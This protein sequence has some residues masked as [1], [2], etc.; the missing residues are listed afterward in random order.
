MWTRSQE[1]GILLSAQDETI[2]PLSFINLVEAH[3]LIALRRTHHVPMQR[4]R[5]ALQ[6]M[7]KHF[8]TPFPLAELDLETDGYDLFVRELGLTINASKTGQIAIPSILSS[9][10]KRIERDKDNIPKRFYPFPYERSPK[11]VVMDPTVQYGR[12]VIIGTRVT[13]VM[14]FD[15]YSGG[16]SL[17][18]I[19]RDYD[20]ELSCIEEALRCEIE[21]RAA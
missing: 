10:L 2:A 3:V 21:Q 6:W 13:S 16:E 14:I 5:V 18:N 15:R 12:P 8:N 17:S 7:R 1:R 19:A 4:I 20:L 11:T 9:Y